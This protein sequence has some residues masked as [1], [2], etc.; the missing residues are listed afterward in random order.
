MIHF[1]LV[2][3][4]FCFEQKY[5]KMS[6][7]SHAERLQIIMERER[8]GKKL[9]TIARQHKCTPAAIS[10]ILSHYNQTGKL[11]DGKSTGRPTCLNNEEMKKLDELIKRK[12]TA[13]GIVLANDISQL[14]HKRISVRTVQRYRR[15]LGYRPYQQV[16]K[17]SLTSAQQQSKL[18]FSQKYINT[19]IKKWLFTDEKIFIIQN[20]GTIAWVKSGSQ[21]PTHYVDNIKTHVQLWGVIWWGGKVFSRYEG[22][23]NSLLYQQLLTTYLATHISN[24]RHRFFYQ[25]NI[26]LHKTPAML[27]W[28]EENRLEL[29]DVPAYSPEF[30]AIEYV[31]SWLKNYVQRQQPKTKVELEQAI[32]NGCDAIPQKVIQSYILHILTVMQGVVNA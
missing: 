25:D 23:M 9:E 12:P 19:N 11:N 28:F 4:V 31:W 26:P 32:D 7:F 20:T 30:N 21:R 6:H 10:K 3:F 15:E 22:Y 2:S 27:T 5:S 29:I 16:V 14:I 13:T 17:K 1:R 24:H 8:D 18:L